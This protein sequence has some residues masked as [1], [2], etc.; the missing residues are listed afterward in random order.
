MNLITS[1]EGFIGF[2]VLLI[3]LIFWLMILMAVGATIHVWDPN[4][5]GVNAAQNIMYSTFLPMMLIMFMLTCDVR[6]HFKLRPRMICSF[7]ITT[8]SVLICF[9]LTF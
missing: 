1:A 9:T 5:E 6:D 7:L 4:A 3:A 8:V 2:M